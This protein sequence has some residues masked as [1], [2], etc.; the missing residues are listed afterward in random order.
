MPDQFL[1]LRRDAFAVQ[2][3]PAGDQRN[4]SAYALAKAIIGPRA[5]WADTDPEVAARWL[6]SRGA[7]IDQA[8]AGAAE[9]EHSL[10]GLYALQYGEDAPTFE[11]LAAYITE[12]EARS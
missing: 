6:A 5:P 2:A 10:R 1:A 9:F 3:M 11:A 4:K 7:G 8:L 12:V